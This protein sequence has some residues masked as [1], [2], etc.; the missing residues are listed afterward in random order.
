M[1]PVDINLQPDRAPSGDA[2]LAQPPAGI[3][4]IEI[5]VQAFAVVGAQIGLA[6]LLVVPGLIAATRL[7][8][9]EDADQA[10]MRAA[11]AQNLVHLL[12]LA[13][14]LGAPNELDSQAVLGGQLL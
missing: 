7:H 1:M 10:R 8:S 9:R 3:D 11:P 14:T 6:R 5:V 4:E 13:E 2:H 12:F